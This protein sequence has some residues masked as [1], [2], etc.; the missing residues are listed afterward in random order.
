MVERSENLDMKNIHF[1]KAFEHGLGR[2]YIYVKESGDAAVRD[3]IL[4]HCIKNPCYDTQGESSRA[5]WL[6]SV[7]DLCDDPKYYTE[8]IIENVSL[9]NDDRDLSQLYDLCLILAKRGNK[10][11]EKAIYDRFDKQEFNEAWL[12]GDQIIELHGLEGLTHVAK[13]IGRRMLNDNGY[14]DGCTYDYACELLGKEKVDKY[15]VQLANTDPS[16]TAYLKDSHEI[17]KLWSKP[18][19][20]DAAEK[21]RDR[22]RKELPLAK[23]RTFIEEGNSHPSRCL[24]F[25][26]YATDE[27]IN[28]LYK[29]LLKEERED[30]LI[31]GLWVFRSRELPTLDEKIFSLIKSSREDL[32]LAAIA[33]LMHTSHPRVREIAISLYNA[34]DVNRFVEGIDLFVN[35]YQLG[36]H[37]YIERALIENDDK[38]ILF[39]ICYDILKV[40]EENPE[41]GMLKCLLWVYENNPCAHCREKSI[42]LLIENNILPASIKDE[43]QFDCSEDIKKIVARYSFQ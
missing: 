23:I 21:V 42:E 17:C 18:S 28:I 10:F 4:R 12:G 37:R 16:I 43:C 20:K 25:G 5:Q 26:R 27:E 14:W 35:N 22:T 31:R 32:R 1:N 11:A 9:A 15:F 13:I 34:E 19:K 2:A 38:N 6:M 7:I 40:Y 33:A 41:K 3:I 30:Q 36:D 24:R 39:S 8:K 29:I